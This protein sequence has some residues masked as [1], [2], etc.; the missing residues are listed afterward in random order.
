MGKPQEG[1]QF[2]F[3]Y[4]VGKCIYIYLLDVVYDLVLVEHSSYITSHKIISNFIPEGRIIGNTLS[5]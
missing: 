2:T 4:V 5:L 1:R 3:S